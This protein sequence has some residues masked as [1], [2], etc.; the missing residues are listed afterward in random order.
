MTFHVDDK[1]S[2][3]AFAT[4]EESMNTV[5]FKPLSNSACTNIVPHCP[6]VT[7]TEDG[8]A[9]LIAAHGYPKSYVQFI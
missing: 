9:G 7:N 8:A 2:N 4:T 3:M 5:T 1:I 6:L